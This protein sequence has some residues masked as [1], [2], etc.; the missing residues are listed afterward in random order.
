[1]SCVGQPQRPDA[2]TPKGKFFGCNLVHNV[3]R[4][5]DPLVVVFDDDACLAVEPLGRSWFEIRSVAQEISV[6]LAPDVPDGREVRRT[7][8]K[9]NVFKHVIWFIS[10]YNIFNHHLPH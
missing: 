9:A 2:N 5:A 10:I 6:A 4:I 3:D 7:E 8:S 1:M